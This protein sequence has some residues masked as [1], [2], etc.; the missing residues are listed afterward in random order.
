MKL[1]HGSV[2]FSLGT[3][4]SKEDIDYLLD[5]LPPIVERIRSMSPLYS[6]K[7]K[8]EVHKKAVLS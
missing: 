8:S 5:V 3:E 4:N 1:A 7:S 2:R 6:A